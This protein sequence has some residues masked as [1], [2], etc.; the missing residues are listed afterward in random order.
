MNI[1][2]AAKSAW[3]HV[4]AWILRTRT[5][6]QDPVNYMRDNQRHRNPL[7]L[8]RQQIRADAKETGAFRDINDLVSDAKRRLESLQRMRWPTSGHHKDIAAYCKKIGTFVVG[9]EFGVYADHLMSRHR[10]SILVASLPVINGEDHDSVLT[11][12]VYIKRLTHHDARQLGVFKGMV[13]EM[14]YGLPNTDTQPGGWY[15]ACYVKVDDDGAVSVMH[16]QM[17]RTVD[18]GKGHRR[19]SYISRYYGEMSV[20]RERG[21]FSWDESFRVVMNYASMRDNHWSV[22]V[23]DGENRISYSVP[24]NDGPRMFRERKKDGKRIFHAV[25]GHVRKDGFTV[26]PHYRGNRK[27]TLAGLDVTVQIPGLHRG[28][29]MF[30]PTFAEPGDNAK[31]I[32]VSAAADS[33][34][35]TMHR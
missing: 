34:A 6:E 3:H 33:I 20:G 24:Q 26:R 12:Y 11:D 21:R 4:M 2:V 17:Q 22:T 8:Q 31:I 13:Y 30:L 18:V 23:S 14:G 1:I 9:P 25:A 10:P 27:F 7:T 16:G 5:P 29:L 19:T 15:W 28:S 32:E 35:S